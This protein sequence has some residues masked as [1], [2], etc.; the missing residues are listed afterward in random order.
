MKVFLNPIYTGEDKGDGGVRR[1]VEAQIQ[2]LP[3]YGWDVVASPDSAD[4]LASHIIL[5]SQLERIH[6]KPLVLHNHGLYWHEFEWPNWSHKVNKEIMKAVRRVDALTAPSE[7]VAQS[8][9]RNSLRPV[10]VIGHGINLEEWSGFRNSKGYVLWNKT[11][12]DPVCTNDAMNELAKRAPD[13]PF[14]ATLADESIPNMKVTGVV[15][16]EEAKGFVAEAGVYLCNVR[17][18]FGI[19]TL[20][21]MASGVPVLGWR[22]GGQEDIVDHQLT[23]YLAEPYDYDDLLKGLRYCLEHREEMGSN[24]RK[25][26]EDRFQWKDVIGKYALLYERVHKE[27]YRPRPK[28]SVVIPA[29]NLERFLPAALDSV[30]VQTEQDW[31]CIIV[32]D[33]SPDDTAKIA[34]RYCK[35]DKRFRLV[36]NKENKYLAGSLNAGI[37]KAKGKFILPLDADN[38]IAPTTLEQLSAPLMGNR[39]LHI[40]YGAVLFVDE[41][42]KTPTVYRGNEGH[43]GHS[44]WPPVFRSEWQVTAHASD[45]R[46]ANL[47]P[48]TALFRREV[49]ELTG[50]Y[51]RRYR[52]AED[53]DYWTR[54]TSYGFLAKRVTDSDTLIYRNREDSMSRTEE[55]LDWQRWLPW[56]QDLSLPP[57]A[58]ASVQA[59]PVPSHDPPLISVIIPVGPDH[60]EFVVDAL[61]S[62]D[63]Q[64]LRDWE[65]IVVNDSGKP[66]PWLPSWARLITTPGELGV[67]AARNLGIEQARAPLFLP[68]DADDAL[69]PLA[70][71]TLWE[72]QR[73]LGGYVYSDFYERWEGKKATVWE[74]SDYD[75]IK[76]MTEGCLHA[77]TALY[78]TSD[79]EKVGGF[80]EN[81]PAW[82]D[83]DFQLALCEIGVCGTRASWPLFTYR[84]DTG[85][86]REKNYA[87]FES[88]REGIYSKWRDY[89]EGR[90]ELMGCSRCPGGGGGKASVQRQ[91]LDA[92][93]VVLPS[94]PQN[95]SSEDFVRVEYVGRMQGARTYKP[96]SGLSYSFSALPTGRIKLVRKEDLDFFRSKPDFKIGES[97]PV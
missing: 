42:G 3:S 85:M 89:Y 53:A 70:L 97:V 84:K 29:Y 9:R 92:A 44:G 23:G 13:I 5:T 18:T 31:E 24:A 78:R 54:A 8:L 67:A 58:I 76:L 37:S 36:Q 46:P 27:F 28:I 82:E 86:R 88:S 71:S 90:K 95:G 19:G 79:W 21:A 16:Y 72:M 26:V 94:V 49:W 32:D 10:P 39:N 75:G 25:V 20:E 17:E 59:P 77:V 91:R 7:W 15:P 14:V 50:G 41:D 45:G 6:D 55:L 81:L 11:R 34:R 96:P 52:T 30:K 60:T 51:R 4:V 87:E 69:E 2:H 57:A 64:N 80:D 68:L 38:L 73:D 35:E 63:A 40:T 62:V 61:D 1:V 47:I 43:P 83:W 56:S 66:L 74:V 22:W 48:S 93:R 33:A 65:C 12:V